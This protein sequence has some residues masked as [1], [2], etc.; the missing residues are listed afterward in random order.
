VIQSTGSPRRI[1]RGPPAGATVQRLSFEE[2][3]GIQPL[4]DAVAFGSA[5]GGPLLSHAWLSTTARFVGSHL[6]DFHIYIAKRGSEPVAIGAFQV[7]R[8]FCR[9]LQFAGGQPLLDAVGVAYLAGEEAAGFE[10]IR[11]AVSSSR[12]DSLVFARL[13]PLLAHRC[14]E[15]PVAR[16]T[17]V[18]KAKILV[19]FQ[20]LD[21][22]EYRRISLGGKFGTEMHRK[23]RRLG[24]AGHF[25]LRRVE[26]AR[27]AM[28]TLGR[29]HILSCAH[30]GHRCLY[31]GP[32]LR[33]FYSHAQQAARDGW[34]A[35]YQLILDDEPIAA[36]LALEKGPR[37]WMTHL[38]YNP[39]YHRYGPGMILIYRMLEDEIAR[40]LK[41][42]DFGIGDSS[43]KRRFGNREESWFAVSARR[44]GFNSWVRSASAKSLEQ[45][46]RGPQR[47]VGRRLLLYR[48]GGASGQLA[49]LES[50]VAADTDPSAPHS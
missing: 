29:L 3:R 21:W 15:L 5:D 1:V 33:L 49:S 26:D 41:T 27:P 6:L 37:A 47:S 36:I 18:R 42:F 13:P 45:M 40:G 4:W 20:S 14:D 11:A 12:F 25:T 22:S 24:E 34:L 30:W 16:V 19:D 8:G 50:Q 7:N 44:S 38:A 9:T 10:I 31:R 28:A 17:I 32:W 35:S 43:F 23:E 2:F 48:A 39:A 46:K